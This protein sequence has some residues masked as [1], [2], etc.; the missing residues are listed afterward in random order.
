VPSTALRNRAR[1]GAPA[2]RSAKHPA[3]TDAA[4][5]E[6][7]SDHELER[8]HLGMVKGEVELGPLEEHLLICSWCVERAMRVAAYVDTIRTS[9]IK[10]NFDLE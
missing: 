3:L 6:H 1:A 2:R 7:I 5:R 10:G 4:Q 9:A 8:Y